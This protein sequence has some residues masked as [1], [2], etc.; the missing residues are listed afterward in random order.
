[1]ANKM[2]QYPFVNFIYIQVNKSNLV[3]VPAR[4]ALCKLYL[5][6][7]KLQSVKKDDT[8]I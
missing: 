2:L 3:M 4:S 6:I 7:Q 1:M 8:P 5:R